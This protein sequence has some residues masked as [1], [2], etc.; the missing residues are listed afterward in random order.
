MNFELIS[1]T[2]TLAEQWLATNTDNNRRLSKTTIQ[3]YAADMIRDRW[4]PTGEAIKFDRQ[5]RLIDGQHRLNAVVAARKTVQM[6]VVRD[7]SS[8]VIQV[9]DTGKPRSAADA[10]TIAG[11][12]GYSN[13]LAALARK[14][15]AHNAGTQ[16]IL[17]QKKI[18][19]TGQPI[20]NQ[21]ITEYCAAHDLTEHVRFAHRMKYQAVTGA[22]NYGEYAF[23]HWMFSRIDATSAEQ[24]LSKLA[25][26]EDVAAQSP[27]RALIQKL[28]RSAVAL[29]GKMKLHAIIQA[30]N[31]FRTGQPL[32]VIHVGR[33]LHDEHIPQAV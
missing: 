21:D 3:R 10:L 30:W 2:P 31:A 4:Q 14:I 12:N 13:E 8:E 24:F 22:L 20:T 19:I 9:L 28:T 23:F 15:I 29:D 1:V 32:T 27:I 17:Q 11:H 16:S 18:R 25:T 26:L 7:L 5:G 33:L 6:L